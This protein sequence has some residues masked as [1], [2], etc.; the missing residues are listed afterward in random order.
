MAPCTR[1]GNDHTRGTRTPR[2]GLR[3]TGRKSTR[4][5]VGPL[6]HWPGRLLVG[7]SVDSWCR[8]VDFGES[9]P[10]IMRKLEHE[11]DQH[12]ERPQG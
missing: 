11:S 7:P 6:I 2:P 1:C 10:P 9:L 12:V 3:A 8:Y 5:L 4:G